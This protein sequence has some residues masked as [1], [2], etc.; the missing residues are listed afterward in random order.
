MAAYG[1]AAGTRL[2][3]LVMG[4]LEEVGQLRV[5]VEGSETKVLGVRHFI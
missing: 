3:N 4:N 5:Q 1:K 2:K